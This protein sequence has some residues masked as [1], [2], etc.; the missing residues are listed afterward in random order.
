MDYRSGLAATIAA[1]RRTDTLTGEFTKGELVAAMRELGKTRTDCHGKVEVILDGKA[2]GLDYRRIDLTNSG[3]VY[4]ALKPLCWR[5]LEHHNIAMPFL[6]AASDAVVATNGVAMVALD[7]PAGLEI[8]PRGKDKGMFYRNGEEHTVSWT[9]LFCGHGIEDTPYALCE[10]T[11]LFEVTKG[12]NIHNLIAVAA[13]CSKA[14]SHDDDAGY[15][16]HLCLWVGKRQLDPV[17][18]LEVVRA[19]FKMGCKTIEIY[20]RSTDGYWDSAY[21]TPLRFVGRGADGRVSG[22]LMP[23]RYPDETTLS[24]VL[25]LEEAKR[26][27]A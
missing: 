3:K 24:M 1:Q 14:Y 5:G 6:D 4:A 23:F 11:K 20:E 2:E 8:D 13:E 10:H 16:Q 15:W 7:R 18:M 25:P 12:G 17:Q 27:A 9:A 19:M 22:L 26:K 21:R